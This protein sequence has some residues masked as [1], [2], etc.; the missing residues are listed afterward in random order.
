[1][2]MVKPKCLVIFAISAHVTSIELMT[3]TV[4]AMKPWNTRLLALL[5]FLSLPIFSSSRIILGVV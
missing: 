3:L 5:C 4:K 2:S 1:M